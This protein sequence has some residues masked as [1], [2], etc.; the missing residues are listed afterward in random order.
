[1]RSTKERHRA[2]ENVELSDIVIH[3]AKQ[4]LDIGTIGVERPVIRNLRLSNI[5]YQ[6]GGG[7]LQMS[8]IH[9][10]ARAPIRNLTISNLTIADNLNTTWLSLEH[11]EN[12]KISG[13]HLDLPRARSALRATSCENVKCDDWIFGGMKGNG[14]TICL[15]NVDGFHLERSTPP[16]VA[17]FMA[18]AGK[19]SRHISLGNVPAA[20]GQVLV[21]ADDTVSD[22]AFD[23]TAKKV[24]VQDFKIPARSNPNEKINVSVGFAGKGRPGPAVPVACDGGRT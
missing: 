20:A 18:V 5:T 3:S 22:G 10:T 13:V 1:M 23:E 11:V 8:T 6:S 7:G 16:P 21:R 19:G 9:G 12:A 4:F 24:A 17:T 15:T 2:I 14:P